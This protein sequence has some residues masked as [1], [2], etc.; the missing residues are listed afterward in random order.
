MRKLT[1][2]VGLAL[3]AV[4]VLGLARSADAGKQVPFKGTLEGSFTA[5]PIDP[6]FPLI[7]DVQLDAVGQ[8]THLGDFTFDFPHVVDRSVRPSLGIG[9]CTFTA[10]NDDQ[11]FADI[12]GEAT[13]IE[14][15]V[16]SVEEQGTI[17]GGTGRFKNATGG[18][19][20]KRLIDQATQTTI[21]SFEGTISN[22]RSR[23]K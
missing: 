12:E 22:G 7:V 23:K 14:P 17:T 8:A 11:V 16:L 21:G 9:S 6:A 20:V 3:C 4:T 1:L 2:A 15:G 10:A 5:I 19:V 13:L 18:F